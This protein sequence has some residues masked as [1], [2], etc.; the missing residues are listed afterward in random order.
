[1]SDVIIVPNGQSE[2][3][4]ELARTK[5]GR[6]FRK[7]LLNTGPL[8]HPVTGEEIPVTDDTLTNIKTNFDKGVCDIVQIPLANAQ[9][10]HTE[11]PDRNLGEV[12]GVEVTDSKLYAV[13]DIRD[14][15]RADKVGKT[16]LGASA[17]LHM[18]YPDTKT[19][20]KAGPTLLHACITNR[21]YITGL[22]DYEEMKDVVAATSD[23]AQDAV[24]LHLA[25]ETPP[26]Q[27][28]AQ[29]LPAEEKVMPEETTTQETTAQ[30]D[31]TL[32]DLLATLKNKHGI[33]VPALQVQAAQ[34]AATASLSKTI[35][36]ALS[37]A[38]VVQLTNTETDK[39]SSED[40]VGA[41]KELADKHVTLTNQVG[42]LSRKGAERDVDALIQEGRVLPAQKSAMIELKLTNPSM[43][44]QIVPAQAI[45]KLD[46]ERGVVPKEDETH[47]KHM[48]EEITRLTNQ[49]LAEP[50]KK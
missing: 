2:Q 33:D 25:G 21:P 35:V 20:E 45:V 24:M 10:Q 3:F 30:A 38:G 6:L 32:D 13:M 27:P 48:D 17:M 36:D 41:I 31:V 9:N 44:D 1:M 12:I 26:S 39:V 49:Y 15:E 34:T 16:Y 22:E 14:E 43:F 18:D 28:P 7:H 11:D 5:S 37:N 4:V 50:A 40:I 42:A 19:G 47:Q 23:I 29:R 46:E 8:I